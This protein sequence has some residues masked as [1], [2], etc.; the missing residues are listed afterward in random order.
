MFSGF[1]F[2]GLVRESDHSL[3]GAQGKKLR[4]KREENLSLAQT[5]RSRTLFIPVAVPGNS[6][7]FVRSVKAAACSLSFPCTAAPPCAPGRVA[8]GAVSDLPGAEEQ[9]FLATSHMFFRV[10]MLPLSCGSVGFVPPPQRRFGGAV[11]EG[12]FAVNLC[13]HPALQL[14][15]TA[16][17]P[18]SRWLLRCGVRHPENLV[19]SFE[20]TRK[21]LGKS[22]CSIGNG[23][24]P[25]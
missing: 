3:A 1:C 18:G 12:L 25:S 23:P 5:K 13:F 7:S 4:K 15:C 14:V 2:L 20:N 11:P 16:V 24:R 22:I 17:L 8:P 19:L 21:M 10:E 9:V 6:P